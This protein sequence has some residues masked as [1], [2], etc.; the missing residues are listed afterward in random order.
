MKSKPTRQVLYSRIIEFLF[1]NGTEM[2][3]GM[4]QAGEVSKESQAVEDFGGLKQ[5]ELNGPEPNQPSNR[6][7]EPCLQR[8]SDSRARSGLQISSDPRIEPSS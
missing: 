5:Y 4:M 1:C 8:V 7:E 6:G 2:K 3:P